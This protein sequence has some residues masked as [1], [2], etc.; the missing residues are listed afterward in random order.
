MNK[1]LKE[2]KWG[3]RLMI[4]L[5]AAILIGILLSIYQSFTATSTSA[6][7][8]V[9]VSL[10]EPAFPNDSLLKDINYNSFKDQ[11]TTAY[12]IPTKEVEDSLIKVCNNQTASGQNGLT[13]IQNLTCLRYAGALLQN[14]YWGLQSVEIFNLAKSRMAALF[15]SKGEDLRATVI[16][17]YDTKGFTL[18]NLRNPDFYKSI[19]TS[20]LYN[21]SLLCTLYVENQA[22]PDFFS[23]S[24]ESDKAQIIATYEACS[25][26][27]YFYANNK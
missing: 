10:N 23:P 21:I 5:P 15:S 24:Y 6:P 13:P 17:K 2:S 26:L 25:L 22:H 4:A 16:S 18:V 20:Q 7:R 3:R 1:W 9:L 12:Y 8:D 14:D 19:S 27:G 11:Q